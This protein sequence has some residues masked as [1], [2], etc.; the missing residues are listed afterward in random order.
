MLKTKNNTL[1]FLRNS[2]GQAVLEYVLL[3]F[4][5]VV[6]LA[7]IILAVADTTQRFAQNYFGEYFQCLLELGELP[8][9]GSDGNSETECDDLYEP[10]TV[11]E[12]RALRFGVGGEGSGSTGGSGDSG[13][14]TASDA[15]A[16]SESQSSDGGSGGSSSSSASSGSYD[17]SSN[18]GQ[19]GVFAEMGGRKRAVPLSQS[20]R[21]GD[22]DEDPTSG[23]ISGTNNFGAGAGL[24]DARAGRSRYVPVYGAMDREE[25][26]GKDNATVKARVE[27]DPEQA[28]RGKRVPVSVGKANNATLE[29][30][31]EFTFGNFIKILVIVS[32]IVIIFVFFGGQVLQYSKSQE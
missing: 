30:S 7:S 18:R 28:L 6:V 21:G 24:T 10:F 5:I 9:L 31:E 3:L 11:A 2:K 15:G 22:G 17:G 25:D 8:S 27:A 23:M 16:D 1:K 29:E 32:I 26:K 19:S 14:D 4:V 12:G 20:E 13:G